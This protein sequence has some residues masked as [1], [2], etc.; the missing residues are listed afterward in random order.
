MN[1]FVAAQSPVEIFLQ[2]LGHLVQAHLA[3]ERTDQLKEAWAQKMLNKLNVELEVRGVPAKT[4]SILFLG[5]HISYLDIPVLLSVSGDLSFV[6]KSEVGKWPLFGAAAKKINTV[7]VKRESSQ[8]RRNARGAINEALKQ[9]KRVV[10]F[11]SGTTCMAEQKPWRR[12]AFEIA[13]QGGWTIQ[14]FRLTYKPLRKVAYIDRDFFPVHLYRLGK[15]PYIKALLE[16]HEPLKCTN[17]ERDREIWQIWSQGA[18]YV[19]S[20]KV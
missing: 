8:S 10:V 5:N 15:I 20:D 13:H 1:T 7:F 12:G 6:A 17:P 19:R 14:P 2:T 9:G 3:P 11:P 18:K 4:G 16:F